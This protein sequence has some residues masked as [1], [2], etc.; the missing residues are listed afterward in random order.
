MKTLILYASKYGAACEIARRIAGYMDEAALHDLKQGGVPSL[1]EYDCVIIGSSVYAGTIRKEA[2]DYLEKN[3]EGLHGK[4]TG[5]FLSGMNPDGE[6]E[7]FEKNI[8]EDILKNAKATVFPGGI[9]DPKKVSFIE[10][11]IY[12]AV[13]KQSA[14]TDIID[15]MK[16][17]QFA[18]TMKK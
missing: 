3:A 7:C 12:K 18:E 9:F 13:A 5:L 15:D 1:A 11:G 6:K 2:K 10:R 8:N 17:K 16:I 4:K 14:Y